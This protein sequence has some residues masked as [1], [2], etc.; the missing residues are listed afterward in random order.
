MPASHYRQQEH[1]DR[2]FR[3]FCDLAR[4]SPDRPCNFMLSLAKWRPVDGRERLY[5]FVIA[6]IL[7][8]EDYQHRT[9][10]WLTKHE[11]QFGD[12]LEGGTG[13]VVDF[14]A[15][16]V[17]LSGRPSYFTSAPIAAQALHTGGSEQCDACASGLREW[18]RSAVGRM[19]YHT[20][21]GVPKTGRPSLLFAGACSD[22]R[23]G[24]CTTHAPDGHCPR[25]GAALSGGIPVKA[26]KPWWRNW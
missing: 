9:S 20:A 5:P 15:N 23:D 19:P 10:S 16:S 14:R 13:Q 2:D 17:A 24:F 7:P 22:C 12:D 3:M 8:S 25:C 4:Q 21:I 18:S 26:R 11:I 1:A 6:M